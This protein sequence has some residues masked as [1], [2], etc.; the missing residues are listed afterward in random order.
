MTKR[1]SVEPRS[2]TD[3]QEALTVV[4]KTIVMKVPPELGVMLPTIREA[5]IELLERRQERWV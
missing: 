5:L 4:E 3:L 2:E 1:F